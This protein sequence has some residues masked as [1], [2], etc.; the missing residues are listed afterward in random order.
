[1]TAVGNA[2][3]DTSQKVFG[4]ASGLFDGTDDELT[5]PDNADWSFGTGKFTLN[6][7]IRLSSTGTHLI[8]GQIND[9]TTFWGLAVNTTASKITFASI[10]GNSWDINVSI[11]ATLNVDTWYDIE[12]VRDGTTEGT[13]HMFL[14]GTE[15][16]KTLAVGGYD[17]TILNGTGVLRIGTLDG[18]LAGDFNGHIDE[19]RVSK[20]VAR[21]TANFTIPTTAFET[22]DDTQLLLHMDGT[23][24]ST[25]FIDGDPASGPANLKSI[26]GLA[27]AS[28][29]SR[30]SLAIGSIKS[31]NGLE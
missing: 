25:D 22:D 27:K 9:A 15:G 24:S 11:P 2:Q 4:T 20:G 3:L 28:I 17:G 26:N 13:W 31:I 16:T 6:A 19:L 14:N 5:T 18:N 23:D 10:T 7:R 12:I 30:N 8:I 1:M 29:K 21:H